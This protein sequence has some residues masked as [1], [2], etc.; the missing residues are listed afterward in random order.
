M[1]GIE[2]SK[3]DAKE[4]RTHELKSTDDLNKIRE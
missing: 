3:R 4:G 2:R 1:E